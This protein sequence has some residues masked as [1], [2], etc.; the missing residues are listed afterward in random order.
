MVKRLPEQKKYRDKLAHDLKKLREHGDVWKD[1]AKTF[2]ERERKKDIF[3]QSETKY[4]KSEEKRIR[5]EKEKFNQNF[6]ESLL[7]WF[8]LFGENFDEDHI[9]RLIRHWERCV[10]KGCEDWYLNI[11]TAKFL[12]EKGMSWVVLDNLKKF[13]KLDR[14]IAE[15]VIQ[16]RWYNHLVEYL[17]VFEW[18]IDYNNIALELMKQKKWESL[19]HNLSKFRWLTREI[20]ETWIKDGSY[21]FSILHHL[22]SFEWLDNKILN[23]LLSKSS[24]GDINENL[25]AES[26][27][28]LNRLNKESANI[29]IKFWM[30]DVLSHSIESFKWLDEEIAKNLI[31]AWYWNLVATYPEKF[32]LEK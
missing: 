1:L 6:R 13:E 22:D 26:L 32:W 23:E 4:I 10:W 16:K 25:F 20:A 8:K 24:R 15:I 5:M 29:L 3:K 30:T 11:D 2:L 17:Q 14:W 19:S 21:R 7:K 31:E 18:D 27:K 28:S 12:I 9:T